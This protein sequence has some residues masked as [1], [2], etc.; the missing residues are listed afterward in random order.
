MHSKE[1]YS[2][3]SSPGIIRATKSCRVKRE[4]HIFYSG[5]L[6]GRT[7]L[8]DLGVDGVIKKRTFTNCRM[9]VWC[10]CTWLNIGSDV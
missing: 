8:Q 10:I 7:Y 3:Q 4:G 9:I 1:L 6:E 5:D 2:L